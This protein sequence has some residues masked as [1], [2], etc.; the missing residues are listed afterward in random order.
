MSGERTEVDRTGVLGAAAGIW[1]TVAVMAMA[2]ARMM[3]AMKAMAM[4]KTIMTNMLWSTAT[5]SQ[6]VRTAG[7]RETRVNMRAA[8]RVGRRWPAQE[9]G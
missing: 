6:W 3:T 8:M 7:A 4:P 1:T 9:P 2:R 5:A